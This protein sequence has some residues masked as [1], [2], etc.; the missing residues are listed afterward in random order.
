MRYTEEQWLTVDRLIKSSRGYYKA[1]SPSKVGG[2]AVVVIDGFRYEIKANGS[3]SKRGLA[4]A[5]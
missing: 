5:G 1:T 4:N 3:V 2:V